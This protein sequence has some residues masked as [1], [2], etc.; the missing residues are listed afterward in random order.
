MALRCD[1]I[2][3]AASQDV[4]DVAHAPAL[5]EPDYRR[6]NLLADGGG[7]VEALQLLEAPVARLA[8]VARIALTEVLDE[9]AMPAPRPGRIPLYLP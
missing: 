9:Y 7:V 2:T 4:D 5:V 1:L 3:G 8:G 6:E